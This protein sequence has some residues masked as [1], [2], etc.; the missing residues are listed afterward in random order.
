MMSSSRPLP[1]WFVHRHLNLDRVPVLNACG[2]TPNSPIATVHVGKYC[3]TFSIH[4]ALLCHHS[5][6][7][8]A[9]LSGKSMEAEEMM[10]VLDEDDPRLFTLVYHWMYTGDLDSLELPSRP[11][12]AVLQ[13]LVKLWAFA[14]KFGMLQ[15]RNHAIDVFHNHTLESW[16]LVNP[17][18]IS[19]AYSKKT[20]NAMLKKFIVD[21]TAGYADL[22][23]FVK[24]CEATNITLPSEFYNDAIRELYGEATSRGH[25]PGKDKWRQTKPSSWHEIEGGPVP[26]ANAGAKG[27]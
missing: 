19:L 23:Q 26:L 8:R 11:V 20:P 24:T 6:F 10:V 22:V 2:R 13:D 5:A 17:H 21:F 14:G 25:R 27:S 7:F 12:H 1:A 15:L 3:K 9:A 16:N 18:V 4:R